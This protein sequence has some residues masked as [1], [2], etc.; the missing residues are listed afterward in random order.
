MKKIIGIIR[1]NDDSPIITV[2]D[3]DYYRKVYLL[4]CREINSQKQQ[5]EIRYKELHQK[6]CKSDVMT[7]I[8]PVENLEYN[9]TVKAKR[10]KKAEHRRPYLPL[11]H[12]SVAMNSSE[13]AEILEENKDTIDSMSDF[14]LISRGYYRICIYNGEILYIK[15]KPRNTHETKRQNNQ[16]K[17]K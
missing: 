1:D 8:V 4:G 10:A 5:L 12:E 9:L 11:L 16:Y 6:K 14:K 15:L 3:R 17:R 2:V 13:L 7:T